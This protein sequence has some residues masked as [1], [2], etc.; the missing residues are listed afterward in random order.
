MS[1]TDFSHPYLFGEIV[2]KR[3][4]GNYIIKKFVP[5]IM[6]VSVTFIGFWI[7]PM[8]SP[9]RTTLGIT[10]L[11]AVITQQIQIDLNV[12]YIYALQVWYIVCILFISTSLMELAIAIYFAYEYEDER[13]KEKEKESANAQPQEKRLIGLAQLE[14]RMRQR[15]KERPLTF[16]D[17][18]RGHFRTNNRLSSVDRIS[19][20]LFPICFAIFVFVFSCWVALY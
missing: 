7:P 6:I 19:R 15:D 20:Y 16:W 8:M 18:F 11:L 10:C 13:Q 14:A 2:V 12:S 3:N 5:S 17:K 4:I 9:A 1:S